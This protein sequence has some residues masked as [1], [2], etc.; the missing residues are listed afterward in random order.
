MN[1][2]GTCDPKVDAEPEEGNVAICIKCGA[3]MMLDKEFRLRG[4]TDAEMNAIL[5][6]FDFMD[7]I[8]KMIRKVHFIRAVTS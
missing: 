7:Q 5:S 8:A 4:M 3:V 2:L 1:A 6:D